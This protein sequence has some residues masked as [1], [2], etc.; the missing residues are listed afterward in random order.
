M[1]SAMKLIPRLLILLTAV[2]LASCATSRTSFAPENGPPTV[3]M[4]AELSQRERLFV[5]DLES[6]LRNQGYLPVRHGAGDMQLEFQMS[7]GPIN[8]DTKIELYEG[9]R[10]IAKGNGRAAGAPLM[11]RSKVATASFD[12]AFQQFQSSL[13]G[14]SRRSSQRS[15]PAEQEELYEY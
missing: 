13:P 11:G 3:G 14:G 8:T 4:P 12:R 5:S 6:S 2:V 7:E 9:R 1:L 15:A 10:V